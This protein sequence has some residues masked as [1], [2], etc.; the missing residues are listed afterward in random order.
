MAEPMDINA[1]SPRG[2]KRKAEENGPVPHAPK[3]IKVISSPS[4]PEIG[5]VDSFRLSIKMSSTR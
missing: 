3:R 1:E 4:P 5:P 2:I